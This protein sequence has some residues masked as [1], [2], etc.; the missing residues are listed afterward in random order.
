M[1]RDPESF[2]TSDERTD[3]REQAVILLYESEQRSMSPLDI[4]EER[5]VASADLT[6]LLLHGVQEGKTGI[7][8][9]IVGHAK[10][11]AIDRMPALDR[12]IL[13]LGIYEL[14]SRPD[15]PVAVVIDEAVELAKDYSTKNSALFINGLLDSLVKDQNNNIKFIKSGRGLINSSKK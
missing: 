2:R 13:R 14:L 6:S 7:D 1:A 15:V 11:W 3:A 12:A 8:E 10:G 4:L 9:L 5:G